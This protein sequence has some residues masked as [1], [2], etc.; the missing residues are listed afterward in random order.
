MKTRAELTEMLIKVIE[1]SDG[2]QAS[3]VSEGDEYELGI[4]AIRSL[5]H[6]AK[7]GLKAERETVLPDVME[8][9]VQ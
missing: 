8:P 1:E 6:Y 9:F 2:I 5:V 3:I 7:L 4:D